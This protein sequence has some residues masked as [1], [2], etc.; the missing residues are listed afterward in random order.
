MKKGRRPDIY[1]PGAEPQ[2]DR[3]AYCLRAESP[4]H[5]LLWIGLSALPFLAAIILGRCPRLVWIALSALA[6]KQLQSRKFILFKKDNFFSL[7][8][9]DEISYH[10]DGYRYE[11]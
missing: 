4:R 8:R 5:K 2:G 11:M 10:A 3:R 1:Q 6:A 9:Y 7:A